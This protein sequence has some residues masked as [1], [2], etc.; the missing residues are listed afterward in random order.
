MRR[1]SLAGL[2]EPAATLLAEAERGPLTDLDRALALRLRGRIAWDLGRGDEAQSLL[3]TAARRLEPLDANLARETHLEA[4]FHAGNAGR[5]GDDLLRAAKAAR[6]APSASGT[7]DT[8]DLLLDGLAVLYTDGHATAAP[9]LKEAVAK[10]RGTDGNSERALRSLRIASRVAA[11]L[12]D[13]AAW[14]D[15]ATRHAQGA[16]E[17]GV[18]SV[19]PA[20][21]NYV[22]AL[23]VYEGDLAA[24]AIVLDEVASINQSIV[25][26]MPQV[27]RLLFLAYRGD[28]TQTL[29]IIRDVEEAAAGGEGMIPSVCELAAATL[30]NSLGNYEAAFDAAYRAAA[31]D[32]LSMTPFVLTE[33]I[34]AAAR[35]G[36]TDVA[37]AAL[38]RL[39]VRTHAAGTQLAHGLEARSRALVTEADDPEDAYR[40]AIEALRETS[41]RM[42]LARARLLYGEWLRRANRRT[43]ARAELTDAHEFFTQVGAQSFAARVARE[44]LATGATPR[45]RVD[46]ARDQLTGQ[47]LQIATL[48]RD[49]YTNPEIGARLFLSPRTVEWHLRKVF[50]KLEL[51]SRRQLRL[52]LPADGQ[53]L[54]SAERHARV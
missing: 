37:L 46:E 27:M 1:K 8:T 39:A 25:G 20:A 36:R 30:H 44:L 9:L 40:E 33:L 11:E 50:M 26:N 23:R 14:D 19:L 29:R 48:A 43:D 54:A 42:F 53:Q 51:T 35:S 2:H 24:A 4:L 5:L 47:E 12:L 7:P 18:L 16:R 6:A 3:L 15:L 34:E 38:E 52:A 17:D 41:M 10:A 49:G 21:L 31:T 45:R 28:E 22:A 13:E 32:E